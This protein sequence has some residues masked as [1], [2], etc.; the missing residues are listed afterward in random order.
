VLGVGARTM[1]EEERYLRRKLRRLEDPKQGVRLAYIKGTDHQ[2][3]FWQ[4]VIPTR[5][6]L[7]QLHS[8]Y[9]NSKGYDV[10]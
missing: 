2:D 8:E 7:L 10:D 4:V 9:M 6:F 5:E 3:Y 1:N